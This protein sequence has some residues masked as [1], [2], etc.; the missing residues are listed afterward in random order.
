MKRTTHFKSAITLILLLAAALV[1][2]CGSPSLVVHDLR[3]EYLTNPMGVDVSQPRFSWK[4][5][6]PERGIMQG[7]YRIV[8]GKSLGEIKNRIGNQW[9]TDKL[10]GDLTV[11]LEYGGSPLE[12]HI[13]PTTGGQGCG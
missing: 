13:Q 11:N 12:D 6:S 2:G 10:Q 1:N 3:V 5:E 4:I 8:V 7:A 9:D